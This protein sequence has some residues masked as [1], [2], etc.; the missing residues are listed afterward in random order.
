MRGPSASCI[1]AQEA[2]GA[3]LADS[4]FANRKDLDL[5]TAI[6]RRPSEMG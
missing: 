3:G 5:P 6:A 1:C 2:R 4:I